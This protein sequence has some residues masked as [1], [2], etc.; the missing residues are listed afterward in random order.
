MTKR[1]D[2]DLD[3]KGMRA[4]R[5]AQP[6][7]LRICAIDRGCGSRFTEGTPKGSSSRRSKNGVGVIDKPACGLGPPPRLEANETFGPDDSGHGSF[8]EVLRPEKAGN[9][10]QTKGI[11]SVAP[12]LLVSAVRKCAWLSARQRSEFSDGFGRSAMGREDIF[13][14]PVANS[15]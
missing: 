4:L 2:R 8:H 5:Q 13:G 10:R 6:A 1:D 3:Y 9:A 14:G 15:S 7:I 12:L 11:C